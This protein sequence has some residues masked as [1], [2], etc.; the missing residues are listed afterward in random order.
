MFALD[1]FKGMGLSQKV[2]LGLYTHGIFLASQ[3]VTATDNELKNAG[4]AAAKI[5]KFREASAEA[6]A[7]ELQE[8]VAAKSPASKAKKS[9]KDETVTKK[10]N[11]FR[12]SALKLA[13]DLS[14]AYAE[15]IARDAETKKLSKKDIE[16]L[17]GDYTKLAEKEDKINKIISKKGDE[18]VS[19]THLTL[20]T[21]A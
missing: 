11:K 20:P 4:V 12:K 8:P 7:A 13:A 2:S 21:K 14:D 19:Y 6:A 9:T 16:A 3:V 15:E 18:P 10:A 5:A 1:L 17:V